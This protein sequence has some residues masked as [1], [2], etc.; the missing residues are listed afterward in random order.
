MSE[1]PAAI[2]DNSAVTAVLRS[3][4]R[5]PRLMEQRAKAEAR[6]DAAN[7]AS[8]DAELA[9]RQGEIDAVK[10]AIAESEA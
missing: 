2:N 9:R 6:G 5:K 10:A 8:I 3:A 1:T 4:A 7:V